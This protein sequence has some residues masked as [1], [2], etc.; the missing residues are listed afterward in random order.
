MPEV[1]PINPKKGG[2]AM[3]DNTGWHTRWM[4]ALPEDVRRYRVDVARRMLA[5][6]YSVAESVQAMKDRYGISASHA[7][8]LVYEAMDA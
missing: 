5:S 4:C 2:Y 7:R 8:R 3:S 6:G 1:N